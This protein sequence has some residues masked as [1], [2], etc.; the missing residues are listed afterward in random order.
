MMDD[1]AF[2][3]SD[4]WFTLGVVTRERL[5][6]MRAEWERGEDRNAEHYR[7]SAFVAFLAERRPLDPRL[8]T[9]LYE[10]GERDPDQAMGS[11]MMDKIVRLPECPDEVLA[12]AAASGRRHLMRL[13][14]RRRAD[15]SSAGRHSDPAV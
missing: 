1:S 10:L 11:S 8:A 4:A 7:W 9:A 3:L 15:Q 14:E 6:T 13:V 12:A 5:A 2:Q